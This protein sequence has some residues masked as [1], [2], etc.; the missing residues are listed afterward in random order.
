M[1]NIMNCN[2]TKSIYTYLNC[3]RKLLHCNANINSNKTCLKKRSQAS[4]ENN[5]EQAHG[6][7]R[8]DGA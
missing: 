8:D 6:R 2:Q 4:K 7:Q 5:K 3:K 1:Y